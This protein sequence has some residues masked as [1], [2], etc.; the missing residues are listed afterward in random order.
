MSFVYN[1]NVI[2]FHSH[3]YCVVDAVILVCCYVT[4]Q[5][6]YDHRQAELSADAS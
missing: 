1:D 6:G 3:L 2:Q 4:Y 5:Q